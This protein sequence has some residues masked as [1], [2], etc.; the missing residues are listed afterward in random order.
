MEIRK[1]PIVSIATAGTA[2]YDDIDFDDLVHRCVADLE[3]SGINVPSSGIVFIKPN[4]VAGFPARSSITTEPGL[5]T[6]MINLLK[7]RGVEKIYVG[8][9]SAS[10][11]QSRDTFQQTGLMEAIVGAGA[12]FV[13]INAPSETVHLPLPDSDLIAGLSVA[14]KALEADCLINF[15]KLKTH[16]IASSLT[17]AVKNYVGFIPQDV[18]LAYH[19]TRLP[20]LVAELHKAMPAQ[21]HFSDALIVGEGDGPDLSKP[22]YLGVLLGSND[23]VALDSIAAELVGVHRSD[24]IFP[25]TAYYEGIGEIEPYAITVIGPDI[26]NIA[27]RIEKPVAV[28][29]NRFPC[30]IVIGAM[31]DGCFAWFQGPALFWERDGVWEQINA[32]CGRPTFMIGFNAEDLKFEKHLAEGPYFVVGDCAPE[33]FRNDPRTIHIPGCCPGPAIPETVLKHCK[34]Q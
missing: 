17:G 7:H 6:S 24:L 15:A 8:D 5:I 11:L 31:C 20:K 21:L 30:N 28:L 9:S 16:R 10:Y 14:R 1:K 29:Y 12:E 25:W 23:P 4:V 34:I 18:R 22:R 33:K 13:D 32:N 3:N 26:Q 27:I 2:V 19:Q